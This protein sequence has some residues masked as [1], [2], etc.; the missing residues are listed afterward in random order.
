MVRIW[1]LT[2]KKTRELLEEM[3]QI[4]DC[5]FEKD[6][7]THEMKYH[8]R[9]DRATF[10]LGPQGVQ[11]IPAGIVQVVETTRNAVKLEAD[12]RIP[13]GPSS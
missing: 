3:V 9:A 13:G 1:G 11:G 12:R 2:R 4:G 7:T 6:E 10:W 8:L 5:M